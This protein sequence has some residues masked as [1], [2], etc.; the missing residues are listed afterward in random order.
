MTR[1]PSELHRLY[2]P[3]TAPDGQV[4][5]MVL[6]LL[7]RPADWDALSLVWRAVQSE[8]SLP[9]PAIAVS[10][11]DGFQLWFSLEE[12][13]PLAEASAFLACLRAR[14]LSH[15]APARLP[16]ES[17]HE[18]MLPGRE[19]LAGQWSAFVAPDL[20]PI[21]AETPW[22]D[23]PPSPEGQ[24]ELLSRL[25][26]IQPAA[27]QAA[28]AKLRPAPLAPSLPSAPTSP[29]AQGP[30][31]DPR[32]FLLEVMNDE[33]VALALRIE[34]AKALLSVSPGPR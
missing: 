8:L 19:V 23:I 27:W 18:D 9:A 17:W 10:G 20:A 26:R 1:L 31:L 22:L 7:G 24:A 3:L 14:Y 34:A 6:S 12:A 4:R 11:V 28:L 16:Q 29:P 15:V 33:T 5:A 25:Q 13:V 30:G 32:R 21:F 2:D